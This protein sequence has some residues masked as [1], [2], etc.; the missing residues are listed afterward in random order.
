PVAHE[1]VGLRWEPGRRNRQERRQPTGDC[2]SC[3]PDLGNLHRSVLPFA[4]LVNYSLVPAVPAALP[5]LGL[6]SCPAP[7]RKP[8]G[9]FTP[10]GA[11]AVQTRPSRGFDRRARCL[12]PLA[13]EVRSPPTVDARWEP[14]MSG[15]SLQTR[16]GLSTQAPFSAL[17][18][19]GLSPVRVAASPPAATPFLPA[20]WYD[21]PRAKSAI[22]CL[23]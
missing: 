8:V 2:P 16:Q 15:R 11:T 3:R 19:H 14:R 22:A 12:A 17:R 13:C 7:E 20:P 18:P 4:L 1:R 10:R 23:S 6:G 9:S 5:G 21:P